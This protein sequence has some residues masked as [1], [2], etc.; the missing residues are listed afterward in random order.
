MKKK[1]SFITMHCV[2]NYGSQLQ[3]YAT[4]EKLK[5]YF[6][7]VE[8]IDYCRK[9]TY[10]KELSRLYTKGNPLKWIIIKPTF[11]KWNKVFGDFQK[12]YLNLTKHKYLEDDDFKKNPIKC[13]ALFTGSDQIWNT[14]W[15]NGII[16]PYYLSFCNDIPKYAY[17]S[18]F[19]KSKLKKEEIMAAKKRLGA[20]KRISVREISG[21]EIVEKQLGLEA[22]QIIDPTLIYNGDFWR[23]LK[24]ENKIKGKY[25]LIYNLNRSKEFDEYAKQISK[26]TQLPVYRFCTRYDQ[27]LRTGKS[28]L[29][30][31]IEEF[32]TYIDDAEYVLTDS[33]HATAFS[34]N[35]HTE[36]IAM[37]P[38]KYS[39]R[40][41][42]F[43]KL[44]ENERAHPKSYKDFSVLESKT[45]F[46]KVEKVLNRE[47]KKADKFLSIVREEI[48]N[49]Q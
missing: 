49:G 4:Q 27:I 45:D 44:T 21:R 11:I 7:E 46:E 18:S 13:D 38:E 30:P 14:G 42:D 36:V 31:N 15:N 25:I 16:E 5:E 20:F 17:S 22:A 33:F 35:L 6:N 1:V 23:K 48:E 9:D 39:S 40:L 28:L 29:I 43:L 26:K 47:R 19:G 34:T 24:T 8:V 3:T 2:Q 32:I 37:Y 41:S 10:G 12:K